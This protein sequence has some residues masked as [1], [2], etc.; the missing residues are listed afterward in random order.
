VHAYA[1]ITAEVQSPTA[2]VWKR[3][4]SRDTVVVPLN[5]EKMPTL[6]KWQAVTRILYNIAIATAVRAL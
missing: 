2:H 1:Q 5:A 6:V 4:L 3:R